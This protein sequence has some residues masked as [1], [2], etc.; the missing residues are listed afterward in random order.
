MAM[1]LSFLALPALA[2][3]ASIAASTSAEAAGVSIF[4]MTAGTSVVTDSQGRA[5]QAASGFNQ[6]D[7]SQD[8]WRAGDVKNT[9]DGQL[10]FSEMVRMSRWDKPIAN[11]NY[12]VTL[13]MRESWWT[14]PGQRVFSVSAEGK[15][16]LTDLDIVAA[17]GKDTAYDRSFDVT[18]AD[19]QLNL[20]FTATKDSA[21]VSGIEI[22][23][24]GGSTAPTTTA[25]TF[26]PTT[27]TEVVARVSMGN[28]AVKDTAGN[29]WEA[30]NGIRGGWL[31]NNPYGATGDVRGTSDD[32]IY[33]D[34][35]VFPTSWSRSVP[36]GTYEVTL[37]M[38]ESYFSAAGQR[39][40]DVTAEGQTKLSGIDIVKAV[41]A[42]TAYDRTFTTTVSDGQLDLGFPRKVDGA[43]VSAIQLAKVSVISPQSPAPSSP[44]S[45]PTTAPTSAPT[46]A[47]TTAPTSAP[48]TSAPAPKPT[49]ST[50]TPPTTPAPTGS[51]KGTRSGMLF[52]SGGFT[53]H[54][55]SR[56]SQLEALRG[57]K[58][59]IISVAPSRENW[60]EMQNPW[61]M[62]SERLPA[63]YTGN[64]EVAVPLW[65][66]DGNLGTA[67]AGGY[68]QQWQ[69]MA[70]MISARFP[71][72]YIRL[73]WEM[74]LNG[75]PHS[76]YPASAEQWKAAYRQAVTAI[77]RGGSQL[78]ISWV[79]NEGRGQTGTEDAGV[80]YPGDAYVDFIGMD[81]YDWWPGYTNEANIA[82][83]RDSKYGWNYWLNFAKAH[84][85]RF[86]L[87]EWGIAPANDAS[88][89][90]NPTYINFVYSWLKANA[91]W[92]QYES[93]FHETGSYIRSDLISGQNPRALAEYKRWMPLM[94]KS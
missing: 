41:G 31:G 86:V 13:K 33:R 38:R 90:D 10:Y 51:T 21:L 29:T 26:N 89:G 9:A 39:V 64:L 36:N 5:W 71:K 37:K 46:T 68:N 72:A 34:G 54:E 18:V 15:P 69:A 32:A 4:R 87:P 49:T 22:T 44:S 79:P 43:V 40:F 47:P 74:N 81:A 7:R 85:K 75:W 42:N 53:M 8:Y 24:L 93:Y 12:R 17:A 60:S 11:G 1:A 19:G 83:H 70:S 16:A 67:A 76:A 58:V 66:E 2:G 78:R 45:A 20:G 57:R 61:F 77:R 25:P 14:Q 27:R 73:G 84:N 82:E 94:G 63:G 50:T 65:P 56:V 30:R 59:D 80:F 52:D 23:S 28:G 91:E 3:G 35:W 62:D 48:T 88:G 92:V 55:A 6:G